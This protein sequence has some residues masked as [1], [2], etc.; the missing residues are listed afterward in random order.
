MYCPDPNTMD[1]N[2]KPVGLSFDGCVHKK[3]SY[4]KVGFPIVILKDIYSHRQVCIFLIAQK[5]S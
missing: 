4:H 2:L 1:H 3:K 5:H